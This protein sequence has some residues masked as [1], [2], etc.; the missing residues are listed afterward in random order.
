MTAR[1]FAA[2]AVAVAVRNLRMTVRTPSLLLP[3]LLAPLVFFAAFA[4]GLGAAA[5][6]PGFDY[7]AGYTS[8]QFVFALYEGAVF[9]GMV[10]GLTLARDFETGFARRMMLG[11]AD[12]RA[13]LA[14]YT[15][16]ALARG[17]VVIAFLFPVGLLA[18]MRVDGSALQVAGLVA[19]ALLFCAMG[20]LWAAGIALRFRSMAGVPLMQ[21]AVILSLFLGPAFVPLALLDGWLGAVATVN[22]VTRLFE[23]G[24]GLLAGTPADTGL[25]FAAGAATL[26]LL[27][28]WALRNLRRAELA[29]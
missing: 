3:P 6:I 16:T 20:V 7:T 15:L 26:A 2:A 10:T 12:R 19:L 17:V 23:G 27:A 29:K 4:G 28:V 22:P 9:T 1:A 11:V 13:L 25:A 8:Y 24:R 18:G 21:S 14:G 5:R